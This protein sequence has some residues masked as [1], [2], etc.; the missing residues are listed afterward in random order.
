MT[1]I[2]RREMIAG[3]VALLSQAHLPL[4]F[5]AQQKSATPHTKPQGPEGAPK[6]LLSTTFPPELLTKSLTSPS[7]WRPFPNADDR[8]AW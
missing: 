5:A 8:E 4:A 2:N 7:A 3:A 1:D 6:N